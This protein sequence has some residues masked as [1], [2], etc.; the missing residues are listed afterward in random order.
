[1]PRKLRKPR[2]HELK[3]LVKLGAANHAH[4][5]AFA[6]ANHMTMRQVYERA[7]EEFMNR[8]Q[9]CRECSVYEINMVRAYRASKDK[10]L[11]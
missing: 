11:R 2:T 6:K 1:M 10:I 7:T 9:E 4:V 5:N 3:K 8:P